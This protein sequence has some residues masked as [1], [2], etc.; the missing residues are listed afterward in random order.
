MA[1]QTKNQSAMNNSPIQYFDQ[2]ISLRIIK[3]IEKLFN[4]FDQKNLLLLLLLFGADFVKK[5]L[6]N[7]LSYAYNSLKQQIISFD[8]RNMLMSIRNMLMSIRKLYTLERQNNKMLILYQPIVNCIQTTFVANNIF[9]ENL[10]NFLHDNDNTEFNSSNLNLVQCGKN[11][12]ES[13]IVISNIKIWDED[14][15][16]CIENTINFTLSI[17]EN[18]KKYKDYN[19]N[20]TIKLNLNKES[21]ANIFE[22]LPFSEFAEDII[23][24]IYGNFSMPTAKFLMGTLAIKLHEQYNIICPRNKTL[25]ALIILFCICT[26]DKS[27]KIRLDDYLKSNTTINFLGIKIYITSQ[28]IKNVSLTNN[29][30]EEL[31]YLSKNKPIR[32]IDDV[33]QWFNSVFNCKK[34]TDTLSFYEI[35]ITLESKDDT[36]NLNDKLLTFLKKLN[37]KTNNNLTF[38]EKTENIDIYDIKLITKEN[39]IQPA[40]PKK[41]V[42]KKDEEGNEEEIIT[43]AREEIIETTTEIICDEVNSTYKDFSTLYLKQHDLHV[44]STTLYNFK[45]K[46]NIYNDLGLPYKFGVLLH[47]PPGTGKSSAILAIASYLQKNIYYVDFNNIKTNNDLKAVFNK[48]NKEMSNNGII[49]MEDIDVMTNIVHDRA[50]NHYNDD[51]L[52]LECFLNLLQGSLTKDGS[53]FIATTNNIDILDPAFIRDGRFDVK[54]NLTACDHFQMNQIYKKFFNRSI[55]DDLIVQ[56]P[57]LKITPATFISKLIPYILCDIDDNTIIKNILTFE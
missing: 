17:S 46:K 22:L 40:S 18:N 12:Y 20:K 52:T 1:D 41:I 10:Y 51:N 31:D 37:S 55:P 48:V 44:L 49:V 34:N 32:Q 33:K 21:Y 30:L 43:D 11:E 24:Y 42:K 14:V 19:L 2:I 57:E 28:L 54:I 39:I 27:P 15:K 56:I 16:I 45:H 4:N 50:L 36:I 38:D 13:T 35:D 25:E 3:T 47:G 29:I 23:P 53:I 9:Y 6:T 7:G 26:G 8:F 5:E